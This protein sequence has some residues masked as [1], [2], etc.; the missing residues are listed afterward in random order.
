MAVANETTQ[1]A[2][3]MVGRQPILDRRKRVLG[4]ELLFRSAQDDAPTTRG[5][6]GGSMGPAFTPDEA[7]A[8]VIAD[9]VLAV[10]LDKLTHGRQAFVELTPEF[11]RHDVVKALPPEQVVLQVPCE[12]MSNPATAEACRELRRQGYSFALSHYTPEHA[13]LL[14][15]ASYV[16]VDPGVDAPAESLSGSGV[17]FIANGVDAVA[18]FDRAVRS[19]FSHFQGFFFERP[20][21]MQARAIPRGRVG[22]LRLLC[23]LNDPHLSL[24]D[25]EDLMKRDAALC[26]RM[27]RTV[28][29]AGFAQSR[30][31]TSIRHALLLLGRDTIRRWASLWV[32]TDLGS[33]APAELI[34]MA[35]IRGRFCELVWPWTDGSDSGEG[36]L[37]GMCSCLDVIL[38]QP[39]ATIVEE[40]P[41]STDTIAALLGRD[42]SRRQLLECAMAYERGH[43]DVALQK[44]A[45]LGVSPN[46][47][48][49]AHTDALAWAHQLQTQQT[50]KAN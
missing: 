26:Y 3:V 46:A 6:G 38:E 42:N 15:H 5:C 17:S 39:M 25:L 2:R 40:L 20:G 13:G 1:K 49:T 27:L 14:P 8:H 44:A 18:D 35:S 32:L 33:E 23:A 19:G 34:V 7:T 48:L 4:Y 45:G 43:W 28:N 37:L 16:K 21:A 11:L 47:L 12:A 50:V 24:Q 29:S 10:G 22:Y 31:V 41:L 36:F 30:E 9:G